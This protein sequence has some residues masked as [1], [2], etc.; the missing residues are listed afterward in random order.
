M[1]FFKYFFD[2]LPFTSQSMKQINTPKAALKM[3]E[4]V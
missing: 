1:I 3:N 4:A 2:G